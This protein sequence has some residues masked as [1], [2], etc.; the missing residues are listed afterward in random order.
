M[1]DSDKV[2][3]IHRRWALG[4][5]ISVEEQRLL[6]SWYAESDALEMEMLG[7][8]RDADYPVEELKSQLND[9]LDQIAEMLE[10][11]RLFAEENEK[12]RQENEQL[13]KLLVEQS[14]SRRA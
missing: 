7:G 6:D 10:R 9:M 1:T 13:K 3:A 12:L 4:E 5:N 8:S 14:G 2:K 11:I